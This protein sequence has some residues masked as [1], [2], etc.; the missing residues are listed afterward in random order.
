MAKSKEVQ[1]LI[2]RINHNRFIVKNREY[3]FLQLINW[4]KNIITE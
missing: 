3:D 1:I 2:K 4:F